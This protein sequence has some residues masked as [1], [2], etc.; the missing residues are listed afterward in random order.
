M[1]DAKLYTHVKTV[2]DSFYLNRE[3]MLIFS[4]MIGTN[5]SAVEGPNGAPVAPDQYRLNM[6][7]IIDSLLQRYPDAR[8][9]VHY[10]IWYSDN[11]HNRSTY[12]KEG[13]QRIVAYQ[14]QIDK[15]INNYKKSHPL[16]VFKGDTKAHNYFKENYLTDFK[17]E[18]GVDGVFYLH[19]N[20]K[21]DMALGEF[22]AKAIL[23]AIR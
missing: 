21:G 11:T 9:V 17:P 2:A 20:H 5:D 14:P 10:P 16:H 1:P 8:V 4:I 15:L 23:K 13:Q 19:P 7:M 12:M 18:T 22:W 3:A 6:K